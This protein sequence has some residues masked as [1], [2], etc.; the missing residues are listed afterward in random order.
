MGEKLIPKSNPLFAKTEATNNTVQI[1][2][3]RKSNLIYLNPL[4][5]EPI[6]ES[7]SELNDKYSLKQYIKFYKNNLNL[8]REYQFYNSKK[9]IKFCTN[10]FG[11]RSD[12]N[13]QINNKNFDFI[14]FGDSQTEGFGINNNETFTSIIKNK[15]NIKIINAGIY[16]QKISNYY[17]KLKYLLTENFLFKEVFIVIDPSDINEEKIYG[18]ESLI[19][20]SELSIDEK[21]KLN[22]NVEKFN[23]RKV[24]F[25]IFPFTYYCLHRFKHILL[26]SPY[27]IYTYHNIYGSQWSYDDLKFKESKKSINYNIF[28]LNKIYNL[29]KKNKINMSLIILTH[30]SNLIHDKSNSRLG[31]V[32]KNFCENKCKNFINVHK[33]FFTKDK[34]SIFEAKRLIKNYFIKSDPHF[35]S[36]GNEYIAK[37]I[38]KHL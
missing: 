14:F 5:F 28:Y 16:D 24:F 3:F 37:Q 26:P 20:T 19:N 33:T 10:N 31:L 1:N 15:L 23:L 17:Y 4:N 29:L 8:N 38:L 36:E 35:N 18:S 13:D 21:I 6:N 25:D 9:K 27:Y 30:P 22:E 12:C 7:S 2:E 34:L 32:F 11:F